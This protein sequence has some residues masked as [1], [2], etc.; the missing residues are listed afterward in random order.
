[1]FVM[2]Y[3]QIARQDCVESRYSDEESRGRGWRMGRAGSRIYLALERR[4]AW[5][6]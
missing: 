1:M 2:G 4:F 3:A 5:W 6:G